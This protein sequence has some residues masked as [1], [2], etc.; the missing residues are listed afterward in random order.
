M[1]TRKLTARDLRILILDEA[2]KANK[3]ED[4]V[5]T[6]VYDGKKYAASAGSV[7]SLEKHGMSAE[8]AV[9]AGDFDWASNPMAAAQAAHIVASG[10]PT[11]PK[12]T[13]ISESQLRSMIRQQ[14]LE[15]I[16][17]GSV[18]KALGTVLKPIGD[19][20]DRAFNLAKNDKQ[21]AAVLQM[22]LDK[23][24]ISGKDAVKVLSLLAKDERAEK[25]AKNPMK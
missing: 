25:G 23:M 2:A 12:G 14:L 22:I 6:R 11:V 16:D 8:K 1:R 20:L 24:G 15:D 13:K 19:K 17:G 3:S 7:A 9:K 21:K 4:G 5:M 18:E 10:K